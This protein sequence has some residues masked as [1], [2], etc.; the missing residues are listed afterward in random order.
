MSENQTP[1]DWK[2]AAES[3]QQNGHKD[4]AVM[5]WRE[6]LWLRPDDL[7]ALAGLA[8]CGEIKP[9]IEGLQAILRRNPD[10]SR[11]H[12]LLAGLWLDLGEWDKAARHLEHSP[13]DEQSSALW[14]RLS[15]EKGRLG[16]AFARHLFND[17]APR[18]EEDLAKLGYQA[19][20][21][22]AQALAPYLKQNQRI[23]DLGC[24][25][26]LMAP[27]LRPHAS[28]LA[29]NDI[30]EKMLDEARK[31][32]SYDELNS[33]DLLTA[34]HGRWDIITAADVF[35]YLGDLA[36]VFHAAAKKLTPGGVL[37]FSVEVNGLQQGYILQ[38]SKRYAHSLTWLNQAIS[39]S[40]LTLISQREVTLRLDRGQPI[41]GAILV[42]SST[43]AHEITPADPV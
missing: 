34:L 22:L 31:R 14:K 30:A 28:W 1:A 11:A 33:G 15:S 21:L 42:V 27:F 35:V 41:L 3:A 16:S 5:A 39:E 6:V 19:P 2:R 25:T 29:G 12:A 13:D 10:H 18:F 9:A 4:E 43:I 26:G 36:P 17:Y 32:H 23:L 8:E 40:G 7:E 24:G 38:E 20:Q 37:A